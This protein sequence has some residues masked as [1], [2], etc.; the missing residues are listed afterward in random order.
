MKRKEKEKEICDCLH[1][2]I[3]ELY[4]K[5]TQTYKNAYT[6]YHRMNKRTVCMDVVQNA[7]ILYPASS[8]SNFDSFSFFFFVSRSVSFRIF[9][10][11]CLYFIVFVFRILYFLYTNPA[12]YYCHPAPRLCCRLPRKTK[13]ICYRA[14]SL[15]SDQHISSACAHYI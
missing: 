15:L 11:S 12:L 6:Q 1:P 9:S 10:L 7:I 13:R 5:Y 14:L 2:H 8:T 3:S 4:R